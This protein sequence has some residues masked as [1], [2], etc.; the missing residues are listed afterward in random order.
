MRGGWAE[1]LLTLVARLDGAAEV[2]RLEP[3]LEHEG[4]VLGAL[5]DVE[6]L[7]CARTGV[8]GHAPSA[9]GHARGQ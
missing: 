9:D 7:H 8:R 3:G 5:R 2:S 1:C 6:G 4:L